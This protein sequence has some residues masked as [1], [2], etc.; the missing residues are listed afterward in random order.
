M[1]G[2][3]HSDLPKARLNGGVIT[4]KCARGTCLKRV[5]KGGEGGGLNRQRTKQGVR[6]APPDLWGPAAVGTPFA[7]CP[8]EW[9]GPE[10]CLPPLQRAL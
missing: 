4:C 3:G 10:P 7:P 9:G 6:W 5:G 2:G 8:A 1:G